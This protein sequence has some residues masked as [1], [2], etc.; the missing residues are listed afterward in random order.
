MSVATPRVKQ[1]YKKDK[2][3]IE[4]KAIVVNPPVQQSDR[5]ARTLADLDPVVFADVRKGWVDFSIQ[6]EVGVRFM[7]IF[8]RSI[9]K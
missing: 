6:A 9:C 1:I 4:Q 8:T 5:P 2:A 3:M 7:L